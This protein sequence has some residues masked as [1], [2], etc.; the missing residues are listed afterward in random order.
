MPD[1]EPTLEIT[2]SE[3]KNSDVSSYARQT[4][5]SRDSSWKRNS[6]PRTFID[7]GKVPGRNRRTGQENTETVP[8]KYEEKDELPF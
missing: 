7:L 6:T 4:R 5:P 3:A 1:K 2:L 8:D